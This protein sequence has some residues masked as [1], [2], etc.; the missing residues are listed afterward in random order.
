MRTGE[1]KKIHFLCTNEW[2]FESHFFPLN[3]A[4]LSA[5]DFETTLITKPR[6]NSEGINQLDIN[7]LPL[8]FERSRFKFRKALKVVRPL[9]QI[10]RRERPDLIHFIALR[11]IVLGGLANMF[12]TRS[13]SVYHLTGTGCLSIIKTRKSQWLFRLCLKSH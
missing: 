8:S 3:E 2:F 6:S 1:K 13:A 9:T 7:V 12:T 11:P 5:G 4:A 10:F